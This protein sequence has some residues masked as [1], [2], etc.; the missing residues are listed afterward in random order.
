MDIS[1]NPGSAAST[2]RPFGRAAIIAAAFVLLAACRIVTTY[3]V[4]SETFDEGVHIAAG[5][6]LLDRGTYTYEPKHPPLAR[7]AVALG[8]YLTG[9]RSQGNPNIWGEGRAI[10]HAAN[11]DRTL[12]LARLGVLPF[13]LLACFAIWSWTRKIAGEAE[14]AV[15]VGF[16]SFTPIVLAHAGLATTDMAMTATLLTLCWVASLW[17]QDPT[18]VR[19]AWL[20]IAGAAALTSKLSAVPFF[21]SALLLMLGVRWWLGRST[22]RPL[23]DR[24][25]VQRALL[26]GIVAFVCVWALYRFQ[27][28]TLR[29]VPFPL[30]TLIQGLRDLATHN[31]RGQAMFL[32]GETGFEGDWR[33]FPVGIAVKAP[34]AL[35][36]FG[37]AGLWL[38]ARQARRA[39][40]WMPAVPLLL[41]VAVLAVA[42]PGRINIGTRHVLPVFGVLAMSAGIALVASWRALTSRPV[43]RAGVALVTI[44]GL[45]ST[46]TVHPDYLAYFNELGGA[47]PER[48]LVDSDLDWGQDLKRLADTLNARGIDTVAL[49]YF[50]SALPQQYG[51]RFRNA[52]LASPDTLIGWL[53]ISQTPRQRG[54]ARLHRKVWTLEADAFAWL[55]RHTPVARVGKSMLLYNLPPHEPPADTLTP[56]R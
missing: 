10:I 34:L 16:F 26:A 36:G 6:E 35:L 17:L 31:E 52:H 41:A 54:R 38:L 8:P 56:G 23:L 15:A 9:I 42:I 4:F 33:F 12:A 51:I 25:H 45:W 30:T 47:H 20:G 14:A 3:D 48:I 24:R 46:A 27:H 53:A 43:T 22:A 55:D 40:D 28:G 13:F 44:A 50:G 21:G 19:S 18:P 49:V 2:P 32:L 1:S 29:G 5:M 39:N 7:V 37:V 11:A